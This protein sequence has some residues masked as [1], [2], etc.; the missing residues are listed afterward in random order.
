MA[1]LVRRTWRPRGATPILYQ[2]TQ[3]HKKVSAI[4]ALWIA[5]TRDRVGLYFRL[6]PDENV[7]AK[8]VREFLGHL[9]RE[10]HGPIVLIWD[11]FKA[12]RAHTITR[13]IAQCRRIHVEFLPPYAPELNPIEY[14]WSY[15]KGNPLANYAPLDLD[16]LV[17][18]A[19]RHGR[20]LQRRRQLLRS[21][22]R[23]APFHLPLIGH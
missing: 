6:H 12:H 2:R 7:N 14:V 20:S 15:W 16:G 5:P 13:L 1:P 21:L 10:L 23:H 22:V 3:S 8:R 11:R 17:E 18:A 4:G 19:R 9:L